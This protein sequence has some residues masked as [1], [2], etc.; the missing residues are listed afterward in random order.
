[1]SFVEDLLM[2]N[3]SKHSEIKIGFKTIKHVMFKMVE[4][5]E[6]SFGAEMEKAGVGAVMYELSGLSP[7]YVLFSMLS[8]AG[9][10]RE[11]LW[12]FFEDPT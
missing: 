2:R 8:L 4:L 10:A 3:F 6:N 7:F 9:V 12:R 5:I 1:M 11:R